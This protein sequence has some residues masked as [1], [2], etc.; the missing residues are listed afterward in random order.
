MKKNFIILLGGVILASCAGGSI[1]QSIFHDSLSLGKLA[2]ATVK[3]SE[4]DI[5]QGL[6]LMKMGSEESLLRAY[7]GIIEKANEFYGGEEDITYD[8]AIEK[9]FAEILKGNDNDNGFTKLFGL[10]ASET[11]G[12]ASPVYVEPIK[13]QYDV[14]LDIQR[15]TYTT[16]KVIYH[17]SVKKTW[18]YTIMDYDITMLVTRSETSAG[19]FW[20]FAVDE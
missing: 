9:A 18:S 20:E 11:F 5:V 8:Q 6:T 2:A 4:S 12:I 10:A 15:L 19:Y 3:A 17:D 13:T 14:L 7:N 1:P 16:P